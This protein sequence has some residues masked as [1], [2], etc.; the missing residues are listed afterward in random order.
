MANKRY[1]L[2]PVT[3]K[4][5]PVGTENRP[6]HLAGWDY[7]SDALGVMPGQAQEAEQMYR[8][9]GINVEFNPD[10]QA[11]I[12]GMSQWRALMKAQGVHDKRGYY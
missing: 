12:T 7:W 11:H 6:K 8:K 5:V 3:R 4:L 1:T 9:M 10:G 2:D